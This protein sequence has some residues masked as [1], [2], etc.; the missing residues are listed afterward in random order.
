M[1]RQN[2]EA[3]AARDP[4][5][6][7]RLCWPVESDHVVHEDGGEVLYR[8]AD[9]RYRLS[10]APEAVERAVAAAAGA[11]ARATVFVFGVGL[12]ELV[13]ALLAARPDVAVVAWERDPWL[14]RLALGAHDWSR[15]LGSGRLRLSLGC[16]L[17]A[18][19][20][21]AARPAA[22]VLHPFLAAVYRTERAL[23]QQ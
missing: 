17:V 3:L 4:E 22:T 11:P 21:A 14:V 23:L 15:E 6:Y 9:G 12:G 18:L 1:L 7:Q 8:I 13:D 19:A 20:G 2:L 10:L 5:L 16:D